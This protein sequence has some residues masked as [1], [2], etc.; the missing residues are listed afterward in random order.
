MDSHWKSLSVYLPHCVL[1]WPVVHD[2]GISWSYPL[3]FASYEHHQNVFMKK[4]LIYICFVSIL[5][6][7][8]SY[9]IIKEVNELLRYE[10]TTGA[11]RATLLQM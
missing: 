9:I 10:R 1:G 7:F 2:C 3:A 6:I 8:C 11:H 4:C 5:F